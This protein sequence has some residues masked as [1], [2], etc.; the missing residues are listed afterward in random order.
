MSKK[1]ILAI[2]SASLLS[3]I[4]ALALT[5][6]VLSMLKPTLD[7]S[8]NQTGQPS[9]NQ[10][11]NTKQAEEYRSEALTRQGEGKY[12]EAISSLEKARTIYVDQKNTQK[13]NEVEMEIAIAKDQQKNAPKTVA[14]PSKPKGE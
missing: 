10:V 2:S 5:V 7:N 14:P 13:I 8:K 12:D 11:D 1:K 3:L 9:S 4:V 6:I